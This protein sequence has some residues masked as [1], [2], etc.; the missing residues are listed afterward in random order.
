[1]TSPDDPIAAFCEHHHAYNAISPD[2]RKLQLRV[3]RDFEAFVDGPVLDAEASELARYCAHLHAQGLHV[4]TVRKHLQAIRP[5]FTWAWERKLIDAGRLFEIRN[6]KPPRGATGRGTPNPYDRRELMRF[7]LELEQAYPW[8]I[9]GGRERVAYYV[10]RWQ[11][12]QS[13][14]KRVQP[15]AKRLQIEAVIA[16]A[17]TG[18]LRRDEIFNL[19]LVA[20][21]PDNDYII[22]NSAAKNPEAISRQR[23]VPWLTAQM[24]EAVGDWLEFRATVLAP[25]H[26]RPWLS[27]HQ[28]HRLK[29]MRHRQFEMLMCNIGSGWE[30][31][32]MRH[33]AATLLVRSEMRIEH[34]Q[35]VLGHS[36]IEQ[37]LAYAHIA[38]FDLVNAARRVNA[39]F[40]RS[41]AR[42]A[43]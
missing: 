6:V 9:D 29:P 22:V 1:M 17:M 10:K 26:D 28:A 39:P 13:H 11:R 33:T 5:L 24:R 34:V 36:R 41:L 21:H 3:L 2:R 27:L 40:T 42:E 7:W 4:N 18:G 35:K 8:A 38:P 43:A 37:T 16:L 30:Y 20:M 19:D 14:Y 12:G 23:A 25:E 32:R 15:G 31:H